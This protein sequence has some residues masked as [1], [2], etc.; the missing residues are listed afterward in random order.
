[1]HPSALDCVIQSGLTQVRG[2]SCVPASASA[3]CAPV[4]G[5][6]RQPT[7]HGTFRVSATISHAPTGGALV[8]TFTT[9]AADPVPGT[10]SGAVLSQL[11]SKRI[12]FR[13]ASK[14]AA[15]ATPVGTALQQPEGQRTTGEPVIVAFQETLLV[16]LP[17]GDPQARDADDV[18]LDVFAWPGRGSGVP[19]AQL[20]ITGRNPTSTTLSALRT[21]ADALPPGSVLR[22][23]G[24]GWDSAGEVQRG[25]RGALA[26]MM[27]VAATEARGVEWDLPQRHGALS[28]IAPVLRH[29]LAASESMAG[30]TAMVTGG[31]GSLGLLL[32]SRL[33][34]SVAATLLTSRTGR[35]LAGSS[36]DPSAALL[37]TLAQSPS[38]TA[39]A[40]CDTAVT[41]DVGAAQAACTAL[42]G[43]S[44]VVLHAAGVLRDAAIRNQT[45][46][47]MRAVAAPKGVSLRSLAC[48]PASPCEPLDCLM[49]LSSISALVGFPGQ[50]NY[51]AA[52]SSM[53]ATTTAL[54]WHGSPAVSLQLGAVRE[55]GMAARSAG[56]DV[57]GKAEAWGLG[58]V[59]PAHLVSAIARTVEAVSAAGRVP[60]V[61]ILSPLAP[62]TIRAKLPRF[63]SRHTFE[64]VQASPPKPAQEAGRLDGAG[65]D[66]AAAPDSALDER[67]SRPARYRPVVMETVREVLKAVTGRV[68]DIGDTIAAAGIG[69][70]RM[71][72]LV[73]KLRQ[74]FDLVEINEAMVSS[75]G[76]QLRRSGACHKFAPASSPTFFAI[77]RRLRHMRTSR[78]SRR[79]FQTSCLPNGFPF[80][81]IGTRHPRT[82]RAPSSPTP[83]RP[84]PP[85]QQALATAPAPATSGRGATRCSPSQGAPWQLRRAACRLPAT[86]ACG[87]HHPPLRGTRPPP[88]TACRAASV[89]ASS[90]SLP[91][92]RALAGRGPGAST[93]CHPPAAPHS[94]LASQKRPT[95]ER[96]PGM[97]QRSS[98][99]GLVT[100]AGGTPTW[101]GGRRAHRPVCMS[102]GASSGRWAASLACAA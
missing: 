45:H 1:M 88:P 44:R 12:D 25:S 54:R 16:S 41:E 30:G 40:R 4:P 22:L 31:L 86:L 52:N 83:P 37:G 49:A 85:R 26:G 102:A 62:E 38:L 46:G 63:A 75:L 89:A 65:G 27:R 47:H 82:A 53:D 100:F 6:A 66:V 68:F 50:A 33:A 95:W 14:L 57:V 32:A 8:S 24:D 71:L 28:H 17:S 78:V 69:Q 73:Q 74:E 56:M 42:G 70:L 60:V 7:V 10:S 101:G 76:S 35:S 92:P 11:V 23:R 59:Q 99:Q 18:S 72:R 91:A 98:L 67:D 90:P 84:G 58:A 64:P 80:R 20:R 87:A 96:R 79:P 21:T 43:W 94:A 13:K 77:P 15:A 9:G 36:G 81:T 3:F 61:V 29:A 2:A 48:G 93:R 34:P 97:A 51:A 55:V 5:H 19:A 39:L